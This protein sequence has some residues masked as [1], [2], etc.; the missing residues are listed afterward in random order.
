[1]SETN[2]DC[3]VIETAL[4]EIMSA[5]SDLADIVENSSPHSADMKYVRMAIENAS[6][7]I[8]HLDERRLDAQ[9]P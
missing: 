5:V 6:R 7:Q 8:L 3:F 4:R 1:M 9:C 2:S